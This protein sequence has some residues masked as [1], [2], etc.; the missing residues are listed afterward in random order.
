HEEARILWRGPKQ[1]EYHWVP[2]GLDCLAHG[3]LTLRWLWPLLNWHVMTQLLADVHLA[4]SCDGLFGVAHHL[5]PL[6]HPSRS[7]RNREQDREHRHRESHRL[8]D[9]SGI[10]VHVR[11]ELVG[12][13]VLVLERDSLEFDGDVDK[14]ILAGDLEHLVGEF[15]EDFRAR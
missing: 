14:G 4:R 1:K 2:L 7:P 13:E 9:D 12:D 6:R 5:R 10:E 8:V 3:I 15:L 11:I